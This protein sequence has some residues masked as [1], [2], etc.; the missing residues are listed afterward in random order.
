MYHDP[1]LGTAAAK[2]DPRPTSAVSTATGLVGLAGLLMWVGDRALARDGRAVCGAGQR[3]RR[4]ACRWCCGRCWSTRSTAIH[5]PG[6]TGPTPGRGARRST[7]SITKLAGLWLTWGGDRRDL[8]GRA[9]LLG[10]RFPLLD[11]VLHVGGAG[12]VRRVDPLHALARPPPGRAE[13]RRWASRRVADGAER[14]ASTREAIYNHLRSWGVK[15]FFTRVHARDRA[16][17]V[18]RFRARRHQPAC[19]TIRWRS[20]TG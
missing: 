2:A 10:G 17:G 8:R 18:R 6:S 5:R 1:A 13:G 9:L 14:A 7:S 4:A 15:A 20:P 3:R 16:A 19:S 11:V 12:A